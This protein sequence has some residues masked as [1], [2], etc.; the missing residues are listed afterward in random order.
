[1]I[2]LSPSLRFNRHFNIRGTETNK[3]C[4]IQFATSHIRSMTIDLY[5]LMAS[6]PARSVIIV[7]RRLKVPLNIVN[8]DMMSGQHM[9]KSTRPWTREEQFQPWMTMVTSSASHEPS[10]CTF[11]TS[12]AVNQVKNCTRRI[13]KNALCSCRQKSMKP[14]NWTFYVHSCTVHDVLSEE[15]YKAQLYTLQSSDGVRWYIDRRP[16]VSGRERNHDRRLKVG[17]SGEI[18]SSFRGLSGEINPWFQ[19]LFRAKFFGLILRS[20]ATGNNFPPPF[21]S[22]SFS[23]LVSQRNVVRI[24]TFQNFKHFLQYF[25]QFG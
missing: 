14:P 6:P 18:N 25:M 1:M 4:L 21:H 17:T 24:P 22:S 7:A 9:S 3:L 5:C 10:W 23:K 2:K 12:T 20:S 16:A 8:V 19:G 11:A 15:H 13:R